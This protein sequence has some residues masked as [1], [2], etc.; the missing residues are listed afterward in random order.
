[1]L[2]VKGMTNRLTSNKQ[3][4]GYIITERNIQKAND[5]GKNVESIS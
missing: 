4:V 1:M 2:S 5:L 3:N